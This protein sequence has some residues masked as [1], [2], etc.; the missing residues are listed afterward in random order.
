MTF[1]EQ[2]KNKA[3]FDRL[4]EDVN[5]LGENLALITNEMRE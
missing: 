4:T 2:A 3:M 5:K 1:S